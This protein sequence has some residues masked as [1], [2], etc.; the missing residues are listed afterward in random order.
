MGIEFGNQNNIGAEQKRTEKTN[1]DE[2][3]QHIDTAES[4]LQAIP[5]NRFA[6]NSRAPRDT[7]RRP[8]YM[9]YIEYS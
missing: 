3:L 5:E 4:P 8:S 6:A 1:T 7:F 2:S 9:Q